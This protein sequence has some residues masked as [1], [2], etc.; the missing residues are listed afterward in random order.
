[1]AN[2]RETL[3]AFIVR[4]IEQ[5]HADIERDFYFSG[6]KLSL[7]FR[8]QKDKTDEINEIIAL[9]KERKIQFIACE[10]PHL[11]A[12]IVHGSFIPVSEGDVNEFIAS[13]QQ[14]VV[15]VSV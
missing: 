3:N 10:H 15:A 9:L 11:T 7:V 12:I 2:M 13:E 5:I 4:S 6:S 8:Y 14:D 1:M